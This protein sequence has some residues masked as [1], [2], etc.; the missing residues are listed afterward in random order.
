MKIPAQA[1]TGV[2]KMGYRER[3]HESPAKPKASRK[4]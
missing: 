2:R 3:N 4:G 1:G